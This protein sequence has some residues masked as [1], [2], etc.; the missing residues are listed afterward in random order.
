MP[1]ALALMPLPSTHQVDFIAYGSLQVHL[2]SLPWNVPPPSLHVYNTNTLQL[3]LSGSNLAAW[4]E[5]DFAASKI[6]LCI[7]NINLACPQG[8]PYSAWSLYRRA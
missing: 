8:V 6:K 1:E 4:L 7:Q 2:G 5:G 3:V